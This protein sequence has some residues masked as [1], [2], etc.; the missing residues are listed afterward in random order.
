MKGFDLFHQGLHSTWRAKSSDFVDD[1]M[2]LTAFKKLR[3]L[4]LEILALR[5]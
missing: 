5:Q 1:R 2:L 4:A 3:E